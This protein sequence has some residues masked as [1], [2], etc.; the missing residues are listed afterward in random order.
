MMRL[1]DSAP[2]GLRQQLPGLAATTA[3]WLLAG[4]VL[5]YR[6]G[7][8]PLKDFDEAGYVEIAREMLRTGDYLTLH[9]NHSLFFE[10]PPLYFWASQLVIRMLGFSEFTSRLPGVLFGALTLWVTIRWG[11]DLGG[12]VCG[13]VSG[14]LLLSTAMFLENGSRH[15]SHDSLL[16]FLTVAALWTQWRNR[17]SSEPAYGT[18]VLLGLAVL[19]KSAAAFPL[20]VIIGLLHWFLGDYRKW[21]RAAYL[22]GVLIFGLIVAPW[23]LIETIRHGVPFWQSHVGQMVWERTTRSGYLY[24]RGPLYYTRFL[25]AQ[26]SYL[27]PLGVM[28][29]LMGAEAQMWRGTHLLESLRPRRELVLT[30][31]LAILVPIVLFS[32]ARNHTWWYILPS[33]PPLCLVGGLLF[34]EGRRRSGA[35]G[36]RRVLFWILAGLLLV[37]AAREVRTTLALQIRNGIVVYGPQA[38]LAKRVAHHASTLG[39]S[40]AV[41]FFPTLSPSVAAYVTFP[42]VFDPDYAGRLL[43]ARSRGA[44]FVI[45]KRR[46]ITPLL[47]LAPL[48]V[49][50]EAG[51]WAL[52]L[53]RPDD[54]DAGGPVSTASRPSGGAPSSVDPR[55]R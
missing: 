25:I 52:A 6:L 13:L 11:R 47:K 53:M 50:E 55:L 16:L 33:V 21:T 49:L 27:W 14:S 4:V 17:R 8:F 3:F 44:I 35:G 34:E 43:E 40:E 9:F 20:F 36:W 1:R 42:V 26:L 38:Q 12:I 15:A 19:A 30:F 28:A 22:R 51:G 5:L 23:Y 29:L 24:D 48:T 46:A 37:S 39:I 31:V 45:D 7:D 32:A 10:K 18:V 54:V 2:H 41:V